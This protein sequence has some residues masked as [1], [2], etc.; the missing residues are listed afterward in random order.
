MAGKMKKVLFIGLLS[1]LGLLSI[2]QAI[3][4]RY[5]DKNYSDPNEYKKT[6]IRKYPINS[7]HV[8]LNDSCAEAACFSGPMY[9]L[10]G[11]TVGGTVGFDNADSPIL[12]HQECLQQGQNFNLDSITYIM[13]IDTVSGDVKLFPSYDKK[14]GDMAY[15]FCQDTSCTKNKIILQNSNYLMIR[16]GIPPLEKRNKNDGLAALR[17][18][19]GADGDGNYVF[20]KFF[21]TLK[22][23]Q[24]YLKKEFGRGNPAC[25][26]NSK[27][28]K[29][30]FMY[31]DGNNIMF[32][33]KCYIAQRESFFN[34]LGIVRFLKLQYVKHAQHLIMQNK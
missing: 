27:Y 19:F 12:T 13:A 20:V 9:D 25:T 2:D 3:L 11:K 6:E 15:D 10:T 23:L 34:N 17:L 14:Y 16:G 1:A 4:A 30:S 24:E 33:G 26:K 7:T 18:A 8:G 22:E 21:G 28:T 32:D 5:M 31:L 29:S